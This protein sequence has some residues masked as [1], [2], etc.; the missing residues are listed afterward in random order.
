MKKIHFI[1][2]AGHI[3]CSKEHKHNKDE[4]IKRN[5][6]A[7]D[8]YYEIDK[9]L[10]CKRCARMVGKPYFSYEDLFEMGIHD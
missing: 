9:K 2:E 8:N 10:L 5:I 6:H 1:N 4:N 7:P 3:I